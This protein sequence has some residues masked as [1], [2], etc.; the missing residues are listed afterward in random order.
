[1]HF[2]ET[3]TLPCSATPTVGARYG[4]VYSKSEDAQT[5]ERDAMQMQ[6]FEIR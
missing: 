3:L 5:A 2:L 6:W 1:M 4:K